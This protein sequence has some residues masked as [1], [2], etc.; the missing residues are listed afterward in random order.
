MKFLGR[1]CCIAGRDNS[2]STSLVKGVV[3]GEGR[4]NGGARDCRWLAPGKLL[5]GESGIKGRVWKKG[6]L[7]SP[8][9]KEVNMGRENTE[10][11]LSLPVKRT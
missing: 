9:I 1:R 11:R 8:R 10:L 2:I 5:C 4:I 6:R 3:C 7:E